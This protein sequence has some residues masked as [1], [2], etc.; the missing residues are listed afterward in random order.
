MGEALVGA[1]HQGFGEAL[2]CCTCRHIHSADHL[3]SRRRSLPNFTILDQ[4][5]RQAKE[6]PGG[7]KPESKVGRKDQHFIV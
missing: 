2:T 1:N 5:P 4:T 3:Q 6:S 7:R